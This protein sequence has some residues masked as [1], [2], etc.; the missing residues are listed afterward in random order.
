MDSSTPAK[1][2]TLGTDESDDV[3]GDGSGGIL[4]LRRPARQ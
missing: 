2:V 3:A 4:A 1:P